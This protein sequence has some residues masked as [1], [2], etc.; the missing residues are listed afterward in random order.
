MSQ[1]SKNS[2]QMIKQELSKSCTEI[3][4]NYQVKMKKNKKK[5]LLRLINHK[6]AR[7]QKSQLDLT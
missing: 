4:L 1:S 2:L 6:K 7:K 5:K 3:Q